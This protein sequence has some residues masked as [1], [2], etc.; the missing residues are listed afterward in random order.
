[1]KKFFPSLFIFAFTLISYAQEVKVNWVSFDEA[2]ALQKK[3]G[4]KAKPIFMDVYTDW[5]GPCKLLDKTTFVDPEV[6]KLI[7]ENF[8]AVKFNAEGQESVTHKGVKYDNP[9][10]NPDRKGR[11][12]IHHFAKTLDLVGYPSMIIFDAKSEKVKTIV[13]YKTAQELAKEIDSFFNP[14]KPEKVA[15]N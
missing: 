1:M 11:N 10:F 6:A 15:T 3:A 12:A 4:K 9:D 7:N 8:I 13:G 14:K 2:I 5:C